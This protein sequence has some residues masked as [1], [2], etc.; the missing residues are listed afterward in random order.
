MNSSSPK[1]MNVEREMEV[2]PSS[3][4]RMNGECEMSVNSSSPNRY[5]VEYEMNRS[6]VLHRGRTLSVK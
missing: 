2:N 6:L 3:P 1:R 4:N 5:S